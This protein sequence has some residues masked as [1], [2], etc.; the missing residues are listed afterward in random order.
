MNRICRFLVLSGFVALILLAG[1][2]PSAAVRATQTADSSTATAEQWT[3]TPTETKTPTPPP[4]TF[5]RYV[6]R[7][8]GEIVAA[9]QD[10][11]DIEILQN[12]EV[13]LE[14]GPEYQLPSVVKMTF[15]GEYREVTDPRSMMIRLWLNAFA[16]QLTPEQQEQIFAREV[17]FSQDG[18]EYWLP[19]QA[20]LID[21]MEVELQP[22]DEVSLWLIWIGASKSNDE[23]D[24]VFLVNMY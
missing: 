21:Y 8:M 24:L 12:N 9:I 17:L 23:L 16:P 5:E 22:G 3:P 19:V 1:C 18:V 2:G 14:M 7:T 11:N 10:S 20:Q 6:P 4:S 15:V 13:Y